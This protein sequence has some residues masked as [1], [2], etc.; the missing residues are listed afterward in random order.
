MEEEKYYCRDC[1]FEVDSLDE[2]FDDNSS[3]EMICEDCYYS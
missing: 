2:L 3:G 1:G